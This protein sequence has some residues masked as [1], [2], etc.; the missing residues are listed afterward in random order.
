MKTEN[1]PPGGSLLHSDFLLL[2]SLFSDQRSRDD[3]MQSLLAL[4]EGDHDEANAEDETGDVLS[5]MAAGGSA[6]RDPVSIEVGDLHAK[7]HFAERGLVRRALHERFV[8]P[9]RRH[10]QHGH[11]TA[12]KEQQADIS[13][14]VHTH[15]PQ[16]QPAEDETE[17]AQRNAD[18][19]G[20]NNG[21]NHA[22]PEPTIADAGSRGRVGGSSGSSGRN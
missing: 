7:D 4:G 9:I 10:A 3:V 18:K 22:N 13:R 21:R 12:A 14:M 1:Q 6:K 5:K 19:N 20:V 16:S 15:P 2:P 11:D 17:G 8:E